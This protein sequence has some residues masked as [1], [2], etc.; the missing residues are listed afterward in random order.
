[1][2]WPLLVGAVLLVGSILA[3]RDN[4]YASL[5]LTALGVLVAVGATALGEPVLFI[6]I[7]LIYIVAALT[8]VIVAAATLGDGGPTVRLRRTA[9]SALAALALLA[10]GLTGAERAP[11]FTANFDPAAV[12]LLAVLLAFAFEIA[13]EVST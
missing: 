7:A 6:L 5:L 2:L 4:I 3:V 8:L 9:F 1:M 12:L 11:I 10:L 13:V